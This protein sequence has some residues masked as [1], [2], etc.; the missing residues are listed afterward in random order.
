M[1][2]K[3]LKSRIKVVLAVIC[4]FFAGICYIGSRQELSDSKSGIKIVMGETEKALETSEKAAVS[5]TIEADK[6]QADSQAFDDGGKAQESEESSLSFAEPRQVYVHVCGEVAVPGV[7]GMPEGSR[8]YE[9]V[10]MAG[11]CTENGAADFLNMAQ[12]VSDGMKIQVPGK[13]EARRLSEKQPRAGISGGEEG[14]SGQTETLIKVN[15]NTA[16]KEELMTLTGIGE[17]RADDII[18]YR[19]MNGN[20]KKIEDIMKVPGIK[21][22]AFQKIKDHITV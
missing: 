9:A 7:Y 15:I 8:V 11:G 5:S 10:E 21:E 4:I 6:E 20:F 2:Y 22:A 12:R 1:K 14:G 3:E 16:A 18:H 17:S 13:E 19:T